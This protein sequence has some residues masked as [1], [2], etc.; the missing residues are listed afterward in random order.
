[1]TSRAC[2]DIPFD[3]ISA[4]TYLIQSRNF[5]MAIKFMQYG[6][7]FTAGMLADCL[8]LSRD[9]VVAAVINNKI[10]IEGRCGEYDKTP[11]MCSIYYDNVEFL[12]RL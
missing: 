1:M 7:V 11:L 4:L 8:Y 12:P 5:E 10:S 6:A 3:D 2:L 9:D